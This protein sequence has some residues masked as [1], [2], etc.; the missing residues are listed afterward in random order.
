MSDGSFE[1]TM[2]GADM[3]RLPLRDTELVST[4]TIRAVDATHGRR[5]AVA[6]TEHWSAIGFPFVL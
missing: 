5:L 3:L 2:F 6:A 4:A 1:A